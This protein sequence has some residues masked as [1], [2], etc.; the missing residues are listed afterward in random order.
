M[1]IKE[2]STDK[3]PILNLLVSRKPQDFL[4]RISLFLPRILQHT[5]CALIMLAIK[6][7]FKLVTC[8]Y[9]SLSP[10]IWL[11]SEGQ[12]QHFLNLCIHLWPKYSAF[13]HTIVLLLY[14]GYVQDPQWISEVADSTKPSL[15]YV[16]YIYILKM[17]FNL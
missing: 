3:W 4:G 2:T 8:M 10:P 11:I 15:Y 17:K 12:E 1:F 13:G 16:S 14:R 9:I 5:V 7:Y 6:V